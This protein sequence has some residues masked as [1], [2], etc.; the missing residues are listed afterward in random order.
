[1]PDR[2][3]PQGNHGTHVWVDDR[4]AQ[5]LMRLCDRTVTMHRVQTRGTVNGRGGKIPCA[6]EG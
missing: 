4:G 3:R 5:Q 2:F 6:I 1:L